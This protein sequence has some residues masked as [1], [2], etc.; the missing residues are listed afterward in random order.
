ML[1]Y[2]R[3]W[4]PLLRLRCT[5]H[6]WFTIS[7]RF[8]P[9][10]SCAMARQKSIHW[11]APTLMMSTA[12]AGIV[13]AAMHHAFYS[14]LQHNLVKTKPQNLAGFETTEQQINII[15]GT[16]FAFLVKAFLATSVG[17]AFIQVFWKALT[18]SN[19][20]FTL[21]RVD[22]IYSLPSS[23]ISLFF[24]HHWWRSPL[25]F[26]MAVIIWYDSIHSR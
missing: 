17:I 10:P 16:A 15:L 12:V 22:T 6:L 19:N 3:A 1:L 14:S 5:T 11:L 20:A 24:V 7:S 18:G 8:F 23:V 26:L 9:H 21:S 2:S 4:I 25:P 13:F